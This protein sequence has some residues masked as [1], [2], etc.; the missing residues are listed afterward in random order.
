M[1]DEAQTRLGIYEMIRTLREN[2]LPVPELP[3]SDIFG[4]PD[5]SSGG[6][7]SASSA[8]GLNPFFQDVPRAVVGNAPS[9]I[10]QGD[11]LGVQ[12]VIQN[13]PVLSQANLGPE[14]FAPSSGGIADFPSSSR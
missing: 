14:F 9:A 2:N 8:L 5:P 4:L 7:S 12:S 1:A 3:A 13:S 6:S 11:P 10:T